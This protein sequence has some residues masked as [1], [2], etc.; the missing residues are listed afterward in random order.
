[1]DALIHSENS[2][3][4]PCSTLL[5][6]STGPSCLSVGTC[7]HC[8]L[9]CQV[10]ISRSVLSSGETIHLALHASQLLASLG[11][12]QLNM[13]QVART[14]DFT[15]PQLLPESSS[16]VMGRSRAAIHSSTRRV[17]KLDGDGFMDLASCGPCTCPTALG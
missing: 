11:G 6:P 1:M 9:S 4:T 2:P 8:L 3:G 7:V 12:R 13:T 17:S 14:V 10:Y 5:V 16:V 15:P